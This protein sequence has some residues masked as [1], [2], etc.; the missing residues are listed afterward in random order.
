MHR[1]F[2]VP[3]F[4][5]GCAS[6]SSSEDCLTA[7]LAE[8][9]DGVASECAPADAPG[10]ADGAGRAID[11]PGLAFLR[12][13]SES[14]LAALFANGRADRLPTG[15]NDG[16]P[17][18][19][20]LDWIAPALSQ[21]YVGSVWEPRTDASG[22]PIVRPNGDPAIRLQDLWLRGADGHRLTLFEA[23][24]TR[25]LLA[26]VTIAPGI[27]PPSTPSRPHPWL[28][29]YGER[30]ELDGQ[31]SLFVNYHDD[32]TPIIN[33]ILD[34]IREVDPVN[35]PGLFLGRAHYRRP[36]GEWVYLY[37]FGLDFGPR[38][39]ACTPRMP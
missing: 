17:L 1:W 10:K 16:T 32:P 37:W 24:V 33:R 27:A 29:I 25:G 4:L 13:R 5:V 19:L 34:E 39:R 14:E 12:D 38:D 22:N 31:P 18:L 8:E 35:C 6:A 9:L 20:G 23:D 28:P 15:R 11:T 36:G 21:I 3:S 7:T 30:L 2:L 26:D